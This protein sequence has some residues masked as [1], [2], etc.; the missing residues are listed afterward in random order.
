MIYRPI[1]SIVRREST[2]AIKLVLLLFLF[3]SSQSAQASF[4][5]SLTIGNAKA[6]ADATEWLN[7]YARFWSGSFDRLEAH[8]KRNPRN[9]KT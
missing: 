8:L 5:D 3:W 7:F 9:T 2:P 1:T 6:L 4:T